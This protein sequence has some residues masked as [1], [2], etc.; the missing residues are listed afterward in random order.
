MAPPYL[1]MRFQNRNPGIWIPEYESR[2]MNSDGIRTLPCAKP[3]LVSVWHRTWRT[4][5]MASDDAPLLTGAER[6]RNS[7]T[8]RWC[9]LISWLL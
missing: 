5:I 4:I 3:N 6:G 9:R 2:D 7:P 1:D 8:Q